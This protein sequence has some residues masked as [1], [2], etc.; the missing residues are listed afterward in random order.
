MARSQLDARSEFSFS[1]KADTL[2]ALAG[3]VTKAHFPAQITVESATWRT[4]RDAVVNDVVSRFVGKRLAVRSSAAGEDSV[5]SSMAGAHL[6][7]INVEA[8]EGPVR[9]A[10]AEVFASYRKRQESD[11]VLV[12]PM[13]EQT[14]VAG[15]VLTRDLDTGAPY[16]VIN[17]DDFSGRTD[18]VTGGAE[19]KVVL[20]HR[21]RP[22]ALRSPRFRSLIEAVCEIED[23]T[24]NG[25]LDVEFCIDMEDRVHILQVRPL[26]ASRQ[27]AVRIDDEIERAIETTRGDIQAAMG[28]VP[29]VAGRTGTVFGEMPDWNPAEMIGSAPRPLA[30]SLYRALI[31]DGVWWRARADLGYRRVPHPLMTNLAGRPYI[32]VRFSLN[33]F[34]PAAI[35]DALAQR[36][37]AHQLARLAARRDLH[38][39]LEFE[40]AVTAR[41]LAFDDRCRW[42]KDG[43]ITPGE[44][45]RLDLALREITQSMLD[46]T[47]R[48]MDAELAV[49][50]GLSDDVASWPGVWRPETAH[51]HLSDIRERGTLP[52]SR[53]AR[54]GFVAMLM[55]DSLVRRE[56]LSRDEADRFML[57]IPTVATEL[58]RDLRSLDRDA[59]LDRYGHLRPGAYDILSKR[60][61]SN[62]DLYLGARAEATVTTPESFAPSAA[63]M[64][65]IDALLAEAGLDF[66]APRLL[67]Y[68]TGAVQAREKAKFNFMK[69]VSRLL[70]MIAAWGAEAGLTRDDLSF[71]AID[72]LT[73]R[74]DGDD[75]HSAIAAGR[76]SHRITQSIRLPHII[77]EVSDIDIVRMPLGQPNFITGKSVTAPITVLNGRIGDG[78]DGRIVMIE[79]ADPGFDW[80]FAHD[81]AGLI[82][83][84]GGANS[85][86]A[87]RAAEFGLPAA[88]GCG[89]RLFDMLAE[90]NIVELNCAARTLKPGGGTR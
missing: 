62:P 71:V 23:A 76:E 26:A 36:L 1:T 21:T 46:W 55:L 53:L 27:W 47:G 64:A 58:V 32:D 75:L 30:Y 56:A 63:Q 6:S 59:L 24:D 35:D 34:L 8:D 88:I 5:H 66:D 20:V 51:E 77:A 31:T 3:L 15:V 7:L 81:I 74:H 37:V 80:I 42:L 2:A 85:H 9:A 65:R 45:E 87:I 84:Y 82:T 41:D 72:G 52:F 29:G 60:Y 79:S 48:R 13:V 11:Q 90:A 40:V 22:N 14:A 12:Q 50:A 33:S 70:E 38:D 67:R 69:A 89:T 39:K 49:T 4:D 18:T 61:D 83:K 19:S 86:M 44:I 16:Y 57:G 68:I 78:L 28:V 17:Y 10:I 73:E 54:H 43:G 25:E